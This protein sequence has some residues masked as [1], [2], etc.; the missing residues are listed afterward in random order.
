MMRGVMTH[1]VRDRAQWGRIL[2]VGLLVA[3]AGLWMAG[4]TAANDEKPA[5]PPTIFEL[6]KP[7]VPSALKGMSDSVREGI[8]MPAPAP[9][10]EWVLQPDGSMKHTRTGV[11]IALKNVCAPG[12][13]DHEAALDAF[14]QAQARKTRPR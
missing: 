2:V 14:R 3:L 5:P 1:T 7:Q 6:T 4:P 9:V 8:L 12:D 10:Q 13:L 11:S